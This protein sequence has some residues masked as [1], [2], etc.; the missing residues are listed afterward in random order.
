MDHL[1]PLELQPNQLLAGQRADK[2]V[3]L[4]C[5][6]S[7]GVVERHATDARRFLPDMM[8]RYC[9]LCR[10]ALGFRNR[11]QGIVDAMGCQRPTV[12]LAALDDI[13]FV[14]ATGP[15]FMFPDR[16]AP[17][18]QGQPLRV[19]LPVG[20]DFRTHAGL[21]DK[22]VVVRHAPIRV[23]AHHFTLQ[24]V[25]VLGR[26]AVVVLPESHEQVAITVEGQARAEVVASRQL[27]LLA[28]YHLEVFQAAQVGRQTPAPYGCTGLAALATAFG[29]R[30]VNQAVL[31]EVWRQ[32]HI[33]QPTLPFGPYLRHALQG[34]RQLAVR[35]HKTQVSRQFGHQE[36]LL[37]RQ[38]RQ[39][40]R[41]V[42]ALGN[43]RGGD[44]ALLAGELLAIGGIR[45][46]QRQ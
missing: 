13:D 7:V 18:V 42:K 43:R 29:V 27:G 26:G 45:R 28:Q 14:A 3:V 5:L 44:A 8:G 38:K 4:P 22:R 41:M 37:V 17:G 33:Q 10:F 40:P 1:V 6:E 36:T 16:A 23:D 32:H 21:T 9:A 15:V 19:T 35:A 39:C 20:P 2:Q 11:Q 30:Q 24:L 31:L 12:V 46:A 34:R 25:Q